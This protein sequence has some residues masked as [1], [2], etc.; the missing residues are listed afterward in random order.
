MGKSLGINS[1]RAQNISE[2][3]GVFIAHDL[4]PFCIVEGPAFIKL[5]QVLEPRYKVPSRTYFSQT[6]IPSLYMEVK[7]DVIMGISKSV[8]V[9]LTTDGCKSRAIIP[10]S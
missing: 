2:H 7:Q 1:V 6:V 5:L 10:I 4:Q 9:A 3:I 8:S